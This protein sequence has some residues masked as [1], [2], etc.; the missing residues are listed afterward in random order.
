MLCSSAMEEFDETANAKKARESDVRGGGMEVTLVDLVAV[1]LRY[2]KMI[3]LGTIA[4]TLAASLYFV[5]L[6]AFCLSRAEAK[7]GN[8]SAQEIAAAVSAQ[9]EELSLSK[10]AFTLEG[11]LYDLSY[12]VNV[13][14]IPPFLKMFID[15]NYGTQ[16]TDLS[17]YFNAVFRDLS[18]LAPICLRHNLWPPKADP[19]SAAEAAAYVVELRGRLSDDDVKKAPLFAIN[20]EVLSF[21]LAKN[22]LFTEINLLKLPE[23]A[24]VPYKA[25]EE[26]MPPLALQ[27]SRDVVAEANRRAEE[28]LLPFMRSIAADPLA[29]PPAVKAAESFVKGYKA[30]FTLYEVPAMSPSE[31][32]VQPVFKVVIAAFMCLFV[33]VFVAFCRNAVA[34]VRQDAHSMKL[35]ED[36]VR[37][38]RRGI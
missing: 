9:N 14:D 30:F 2:R 4:G 36:A 21:G 7:V 23:Y 8:L 31:N 11:D 1:L 22:S 13:S 19:A 29:S 26:E 12:T 27:F 16:Y 20:G 15:N 35:L 10:F 18:V 3:V 6:P 17:A 5:A 34:S 37:E 32:R 28:A 25:Q 33:F 38:G 24:I